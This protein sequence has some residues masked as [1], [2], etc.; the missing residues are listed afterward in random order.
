MTSASLVARVGGLVL[1]VVLVVLSWGRGPGDVVAQTTPWV[2]PASEKAKKNPLPADTKAVEQG[3]KVA[4][5]NCVPCH[6]NQGKGDGPAAV[7]LNP[8]PADWTSKKVQDEP[9]GE[10][11]WKIT[12]GR[13]PM[14][15]WRH[16]PEN[17]RWAVVRYLRTLAGK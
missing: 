11:F 5:V 3:E 12:T 17:D 15:S 7:A 13:G 1:A 4:K 14:P 2:A 16:L 8:K 6:G 10:I 9:D